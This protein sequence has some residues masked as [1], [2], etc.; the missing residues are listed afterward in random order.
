MIVTP[1]GKFNLKVITI[2]LL[3]AS[4]T[5]L[6]PTSYVMHKQV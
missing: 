1:A 2:C 5:I 4:L 3:Y 6:K